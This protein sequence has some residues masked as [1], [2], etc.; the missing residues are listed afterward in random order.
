MSKF[1]NLIFDF[2]VYE[3]STTTNNPLDSMKIKKVLEDS[4]ISE[5]KRIQKVVADA[6]SDE[7]VNLTSSNPEYLIIFCDRELSIKL[8]S[9]AVSYSLKPSAAGT[10]T[11]TFFYRGE[12]S[13]LKISNA[14]GGD[15]NVDIILVDA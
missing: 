1:L 13:D 10:K 3:N 5:V 2:I 8:N 7:V 9:S 4:S 11:L 15:A 14:S 12:I 6:V